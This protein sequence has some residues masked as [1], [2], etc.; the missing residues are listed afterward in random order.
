MT[1]PIKK[2]DLFHI[3]AASSPVS[4]KEDLHSGIKVLQE[5]GLICNHIDAIDRSWGYLAGNDEVRFNE[6]HPNNHYPL[7]AFARGGWGSARLLEKTQPWKEGILIDFE[8]HISK[9]YLFK[10]KIK[11]IFGMKYD[12]NI[13]QNTYQR[14]PEK[15]VINK[16]KEFYYYAKE[17][18]FINENEINLSIRDNF[19]LCLNFSL[20]N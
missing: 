1:E 4:K 7:L 15:D 20:F 13:F 11:K 3:V 8:R 17:I 18:N 19:F 5:W 2:G 9:K 12:Y 16:F 14:H 6:L 10:E